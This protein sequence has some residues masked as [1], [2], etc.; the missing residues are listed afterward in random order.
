MYDLKKLS[1]KRRKARAVLW[2]TLFA[3]LI[4]ILW[5]AN[6]LL[7]VAPRPLHGRK[8]PPPQPVS[9]ARVKQVFDGDTVLLASG[10]L[11]R[12]K[13]IDTPEQDQ[14]GYT[15]AGEALRELVYGENVSLSYDPGETSD[16]YGRLLAYLATESCAS[17]NESLLASGWAWIYRMPRDSERR[18]PF[19]KAQRSAMENRRGVWSE[20]TDPAGPFYG[21]RASRIFHKPSCTHGQKISPKNRST[22]ENLHE[23]FWQGYSPCRS[24]FLHP[25]EGE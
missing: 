24:C 21:S 13:G 11:V 14:I 9:S 17:V 15:R 2:L 19:L 8:T 3:I 10:T 22:F 4:G 7:P 20:L 12:L 5:L 16:R 23:A 25:I 18:E 1:I 6:Q